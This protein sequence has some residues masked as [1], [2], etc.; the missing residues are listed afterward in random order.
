[1]FLNPFAPWDD[2]YG[3]ILCGKLT[4][5][6]TVR[7]VLTF[8]VHSLI[9]YNGCMINAS[10]Q[11]VID[12]NIPFSEVAG[13]WYQTNTYNWERLLVDSGGIQLVLSIKEPSEIATAQ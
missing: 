12:G 4:H 5:L 11:L 1:M 6:G 10:G 7:V 2:R 3:A 13:A 8:N 9:G